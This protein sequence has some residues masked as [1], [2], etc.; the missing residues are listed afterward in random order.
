MNP[1]SE[2]RRCLEELDIPGVRRLWAHMAPH[3]E[4]SATDAETLICL[5]RART[6]AESIPL[7][8]R[9][10]SH[11]WLLDNGYPSGLPD[12]LKPKAER[13]YPRVSVAVGIAVKMMNPELKVAGVEIRR[14]M[15]GAVLEAE[16]DGK[17]NDSGFVKLRMLEARAKARKQL[18]R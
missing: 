16:A 17:L 3:L 14:A 2:M 11:R 8:A 5:H 4:Q 12:H 15:E 7:E 9:A 10:Y 1:S 18:F 6:E 13:L